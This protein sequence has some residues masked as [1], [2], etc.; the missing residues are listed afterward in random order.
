[1]ARIDIIHLLQYHEDEVT[2]Q[3]LG[4]RIYFNNW[5]VSGVKYKIRAGF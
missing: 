2:N 1:M 4:R 5:S 3:I